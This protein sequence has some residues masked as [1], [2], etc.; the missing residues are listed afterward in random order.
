V[1]SAHGYVE[2]GDWRGK[3]RASDADRD[4]VV[5]RLGTAYSEGRLFRDEYDER[6]ERALSARTYGELDQLMIDL[7]AAA[8]PAVPQAAQTNR[9][10]MASVACAL[11]Q[12]VFG[13]MLA[14]PAIILGYAARSQIKRTG[15]QGAGLA[16]T[17][18]ILGWMVILGI[19]LLGVFLT[20]SGGFHGAAGG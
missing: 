20:L 5:E 17:G 18:L 13:P 10:A 3:M 6:L 9:L 8:A 4:R 16:L 7:P 11:G 2:A 15:E 12:V 19:V 1:A 14:I